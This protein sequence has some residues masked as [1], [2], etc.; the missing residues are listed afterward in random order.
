MSCCATRRRSRA[1][2]RGGWPA[3]PRR[4]GFELEPDAARLLAE[5]V[6]D[7]TA[8][9]ATELDRLALWAEP[10]GHGRA[11]RTSRRWSPTPPRRSSWALSDA[12][13]DRDPATAL[14]AAERLA[15]PG[16]GG[17][18]ADLPGRQAPARGEPALEQLEAGTAG[19][20]VEAALPMHPYA[21][22]MLLR[23]LRGRSLPRCAPPPARSPTSSGGRA[24][25]RTTR[26]GWR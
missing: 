1:T 16:R 9:L 13:V 7:S 12:I 21:A 14:D 24:A 15:G 25:A 2:C 5:R 18:A 22:K 23:R 10:G 3:R 19:E 8:R 17:D 4:R 11:S 20:E 6:G 26:S